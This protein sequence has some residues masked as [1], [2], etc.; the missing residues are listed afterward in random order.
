[1]FSIYEFMSIFVAAIPAI[2]KS[3]RTRLKNVFYQGRYILGMGYGFAGGVK[4]HY[5][6]LGSFAI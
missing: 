4:G 3:I 5:R 1:M 6:A 2:I